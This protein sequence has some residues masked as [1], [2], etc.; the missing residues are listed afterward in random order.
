MPSKKSKTKISKP[1]PLVLRLGTR[2]SA[3]A[4]T[5][6]RSIA[7]VLEKRNPGLRVELIEIATTGDKNRVNALKSFGGAGVFVKEL[8]LA[9]IEKRIDF[10]V[11]SLKDVPT[12]QPRG[13]I[14][15]AIV[16]RED[17][18]DVAITRGWKK[19]K[20]LPPGSVI[21][22]GSERRRAQLVL[23]HPHLK[24]ADIR[25]NVETRIR[26]VHDGEYAGTILARAGLRRLGLL[27]ETMETI[28]LADVLPAPGQGALG[29]ECRTNDAATREVLAKIHDGGVALCVNAERALL[30]LL[31]GGCNL[32]LG[33][34]GTVGPKSIKLEAFLGLP[35]G[36]QWVAV[37][38]EVPF[39][40]RIRPD[41]FAHRV[42]REVK[43]AMMKLDARAILKKI[44]SGPGT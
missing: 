9:L 5:Q 22:S 8:E 17:P 30:A 44:M 16:G 36:S 43:A 32:P 4:L 3:L 41:H 13:L 18:R 40:G 14:L 7:K 20:D 27:T 6:S 23:K 31:G 38:K 28:P 2:A 37:K 24:F 25:G 26:K 10:A 34:L 15:G 33:A 1:E 19:L 11:H 39:R 29:I 12:K 42:A 21:G 35:D